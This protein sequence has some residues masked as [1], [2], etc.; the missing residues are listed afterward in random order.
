MQPGEVSELN[1]TPPCSCFALRAANCFS[2]PV[3]CFAVSGLPSFSGITRAVEN[4]V[5]SSLSRDVLLWI[6]TV[7]ADRDLE[8]QTL[9]FPFSRISVQDRRFVVNA[10]LL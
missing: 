10:V 1:G 9:S 4:F 8:N 5:V 3:V 6:L 7:G 2:L